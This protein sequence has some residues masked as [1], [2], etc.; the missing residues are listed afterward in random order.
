MK[1]LVGKSKILSPVERDNLAGFCCGERIKILYLPPSLEGHN[2]GVVEL[3]DTLDLGSS[4]SRCESSS[5]SART[6]EKASLVKRGFFFLTR[7]IHNRR[8]EKFILPAHP[9]W[10]LVEGSLSARKINKYQ[11]ET[12]GEQLITQALSVSIRLKITYQV[13]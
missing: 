9:W 2:A 6:T 12:G 8:D 11:M 5:L 3:V 1:D 13:F 7:T 10:E 4:A